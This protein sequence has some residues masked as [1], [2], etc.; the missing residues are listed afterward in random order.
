MDACSPIH[1][2]VHTNF[3][4]QAISGNFGLSFRHFEP[5]TFFAR[6]MKQL[7]VDVSPPPNIMT[8]MLTLTRVTFDLD[9]YDL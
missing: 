6:N 1:Q 9:Q 7:D 2:S 5:I 8:F 3:V 4:K